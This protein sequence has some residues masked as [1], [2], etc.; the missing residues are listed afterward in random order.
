[1]TQNEKPTKRIQPR[2][3]QDELEILIRARYP[4][5]YV[6]TWEERRVEQHLRRLAAKRKKQ[7]FCW[8]VTTGLAKSGTASSG[9]RS[10]G[11]ADPIEALDSVI[12]F[13]EPA[14]YLFK[15]FH[16]FMQPR[17]CNIAVIRKLREVAISLSD[18][19]KTLIITSPR[20][21]ISP[22]M[23]KDVCMLDYPLPGPEEL[24]ALLQRICKDVAEAAHVAITLDPTDREK[25]IQAA[26]GLTLQEAE[27]VFAKTIVHD[28]TLSANDVSMVFS[29]KQQII[30]KS[31]LLEY[32]DSPIGVSDVGGLE[33]LKDWLGKRS[34]A[35]STRAREFGLPFQR[36]C[37][38]WGCRV[39]E[40][41]FA[42]RRSAAC[43][44]C[45][46]CVSTWAACSPAW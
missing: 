15:D 33:H 40:K 31:G 3:V 37:C 38:W 5:I 13:K 10:K 16:N 21:D 26:L 12:D 11:L 29:E 43:G 27:N 7:L 30:R 8:S 34:L 19:Y 39:A 42:P 22:D 23:E 45:R 32:C 20:A 6:V 28:G 9:P 17:E 14:I 41:A 24:E 46:S 2:S 4:I 25:L 1:M 18:S 44:T 35:F 36:V